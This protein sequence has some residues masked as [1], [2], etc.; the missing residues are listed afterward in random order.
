MSSLFT[1]F[2]APDGCQRGTHTSD[3]CTGSH[4][5]SH[6]KWD[7]GARFDRIK[8]PFKNLVSFLYNSNYFLGEKCLKANTCNY[9]LGEKCLKANT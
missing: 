8:H 9:F 6:P 1:V 3:G 2:N 7:I 5:R 4:I